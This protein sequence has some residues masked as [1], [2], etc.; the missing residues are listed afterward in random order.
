LVYQADDVE[1]TLVLTVLERANLASE[2]NQIAIDAFEI[3]R[4][5]RSSLPY[6]IAALLILAVVASAGLALREWRLLRRRER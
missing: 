6:P 5:E 1:H 3:T 2:G 4:G